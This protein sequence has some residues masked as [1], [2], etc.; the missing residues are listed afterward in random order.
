M[1]SQRSLD[2]G[3]AEIKERTHNNPD[4]SIRISRTPKITGKGQI[5]F[6]NKFLEEK[7]G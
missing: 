6:V 2:L 5:Y 4:G 3:V 7:V 1:P